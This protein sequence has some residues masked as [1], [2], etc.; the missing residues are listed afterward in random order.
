MGSFFAS[1]H[2]KTRD[3]DAVCAAAKKAVRA[4]GGKMLIAS[5]SGGWVNAYP[6]G[7]P[8][9]P[10]IAGRIG[11]EARIKHIIAFMVHDSDV[12]TYWYFRDGK[13]AD[14]FISCPDYFGEASDEDMA[15]A[16][17]PEVFTEL[18]DKTAR[19]RLRKLVASRMIDGEETGDSP[20]FDFEDERLV[21]LAKLF[22]ITG[23]LGSYE[24][25]KEGEEVEGVGSVKGMVEV[26]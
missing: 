23:A 26:G 20:Q 9:L 10:E 11:R 3:A 19:A 13:L 22:G 7:D 18:L 16:G 21:R 25:L 14:H 2:C 8:E 4:F 5:S 12:L 6:S 15:A 24:Y 1:I 17:K